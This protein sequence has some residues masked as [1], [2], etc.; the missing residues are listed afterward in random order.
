MFGAANA[1]RS[2]PDEHDAGV[3]TGF[4]VLQSA[5]PDYPTI[6]PH[7]MAIGFYDRLGWQRRGPGWSTCRSTRC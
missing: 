2:V 5:H 1:I 6:R 4:A 7:R 3:I